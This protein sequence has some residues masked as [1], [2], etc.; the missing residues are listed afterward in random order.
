MKED[1]TFES[2]FNGHS[3]NTNKDKNL[4]CYEKVL[5]KIND[6]LNDMLEKHSKIMITRMDLRYP[7]TDNII[8]D[9]KQVSDFTYNLKRS[10]NREKNVGNH[11][12]D[13]RIITVQEQ[14]TSN[15]PHFHVAVIVNAN[16]KK[17]PYSIHEKA[18]NL[19]KLATGSSS[20]GLVDYCNRQEN[21]IVIDR[22]SPSFEKDF[23]KGFYQ[24]SYLAKVR[25]KESREKGSWL[26]RTTR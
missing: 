10:L 25:G 11:S 8:C 15:H 26:V 1:V 12:V 17:S 24:T 3:I 21:G 5:N 6:T 7:N 4:G 19:W 2:T 20:D 18:N 14:D 23:D 22:N 13:A 9:S 16:A